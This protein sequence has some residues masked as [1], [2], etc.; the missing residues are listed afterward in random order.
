MWII[1]TCNQARTIAI[2][3]ALATASILVIGID[4]AV[5]RP[6]LPLNDSPTWRRSLQ[7]KPK[8]IPATFYALYFKQCDTDHNNAL[9]NTELGSVHCLASTT[10]GL[11]NWKYFFSA[12]WTQAA[13]DSKDL[14]GFSYDLNHDHKFQVNEFHRWMTMFLFWVNPAL[15]PPASKI[16]PVCSRTAHGWGFGSDNTVHELSGVRSITACCDAC[17][18][19]QHLPDVSWVRSRAGK[20]FE[21][22]QLL[23]VTLSAHPKVP[24][25]KLTNGISA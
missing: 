1:S 24:H 18:A 11:E 3:L 12:S 23:P 15:L 16:P 7:K 22:T 4:A 5:A 8:Y 14:K 17:N 6:A 20:Y 13:I 9:T 21:R 25:T 10:L 2:A 19:F